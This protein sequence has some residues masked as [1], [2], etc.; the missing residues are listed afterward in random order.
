MR[1]ERA[2]PRNLSHL[3][4]INQIRIAVER[5]ARADGLTLGFFFASWELQ[6]HGWKLPLIPDAACRVEHGATSATALFEYDR[7]EERPSYLLP[8]KF[9]GYRDRLAGFPFSRVV[10]VTETA[11]CGTGF[12]P[13]W[14][15]ISPSPS[16]PS[17][18]GSL[19]GFV[20]CIGVAPVRT[21]VQPVVSAATVSCAEMLSRAIGSAL[22]HVGY[23]R[24]CTC[25]NVSKIEMNR[26]DENSGP[27]KPAARA[28]LSHKASFD[29]PF[30]EENSKRWPE[31]DSRTRNQRWLGTGGK[32]AF[33]A[34]NTQMEGGLE[35]EYASGWPRRP[36]RYA[37]CR[38]SRRSISRPLNQGLISEGS[39]TPF[40]VSWTPCTTMTALAV[41]G[42]HHSGSIPW[43]HRP[44]L[45]SRRSAPCA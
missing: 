33:I 39:A 41:V 16:S 17:L 7:G 31:E 42:Q 6:A 20:E 5:S 38:K 37:R 26:L 14:E 25:I 32:S 4:G 24:M 40:E 9:A 11:D 2:L 22:C 1:L 3:T 44:L 30:R 10:I 23:S 8:T 34:M 35:N 45:D 13:I 36:C 27:R 19:D 21:V 12:K 29:R 28:T 15:S 43:D 18:Q